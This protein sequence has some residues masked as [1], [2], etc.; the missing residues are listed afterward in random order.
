MGVG[1]VTL[2]LEGH[3]DPGSVGLDVTVL[4]LEIEFGHFGDAQV[5]Q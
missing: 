2:K 3:L 1:S 5:T 4:D